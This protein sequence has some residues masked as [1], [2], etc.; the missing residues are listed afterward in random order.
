MKMQTSAKLTREA[1]LRTLRDRADLLDRH[2]VERIALFGSYA[3]NRPSTTS[4]IDLLVEFERPSYDNLVALSRD[5]EALF[6]RKVEIITPAGLAS[7]RVPS[8]ADS[9]RKSLAYA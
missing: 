4:D 6:G 5:L 7:I 3:E 2:G 9:I 8:I 1:I